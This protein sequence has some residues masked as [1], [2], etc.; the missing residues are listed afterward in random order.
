MFLSRGDRDLGVVPPLTFLQVRKIALNATQAVR[1]ALMS[2]RS[3]LSVKKDSGKTLLLGVAA[4]YA[5]FSVCCEFTLFPK[6]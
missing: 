5:G 6:S 3:V 2:Q 1:S 4:V